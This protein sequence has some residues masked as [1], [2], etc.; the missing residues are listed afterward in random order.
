MTTRNT[1]HLTRFAFLLLWLVAG[2]VG[3]QLVR[4]PYQGKLTDPSGNPLTADVSMVFRIWWEEVGGSLEWVETQ[5]L[6][7][8][9]S[10]LFSVTL[11][12]VNSISM[13]SLIAARA[14]YLSVQVGGDAEMSPRIP[15]LYVPYAYT[16]ERA[17]TAAVADDVANPPWLISG[18]NTYRA[19]GN[20]GIG[21][22][23]PTEALHVHRSSGAVKA[24]VKSAN[25][26]AD[27]IIDSAGVGGNLPTVEFRRNGVFQ[28][29]MGF[30]ST[31]TNMFIYHNQSVVF[32]DGMVGIGTQTPTNSL[33]V[34]GSI[35]V[36]GQ[37]RGT[38]PRPDYDSGWQLIQKGETKVLTH[39][40]GGSVDNYVVDILTRGSTGIIRTR[41]AG[42]YVFIQ[43][44]EGNFNGYFLDALTPTTA[45][46]TRWADDTVV[47]DVRVRIWRYN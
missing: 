28:G 15:I 20:V 7:R 36:T 25:N 29:S 12:A 18:A 40:I 22:A 47:A 37:A 42:G 41:G 19:S 39:N 8:V 26:D 45:T 4:I 9:R 6:V 13:N 31:R 11:G 27:V 5:S 10:G 16:A 43:N 32:K 46:V 38:F 44:N 17:G 1:V 23:S 34:H 21:I 24:L 35:R 14:N 2:T 3:G 33:E 30:D